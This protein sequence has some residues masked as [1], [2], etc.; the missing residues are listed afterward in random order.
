MDYLDKYAVI[1]QEI[2]S[3][4]EQPGKKII[5]KLF[6]LIERSGVTL[7]LNYSIHYF[8]PYS[9]KLDD[10][11]HV[12]ESNDIININTSGVTQVIH[13]AKNNP[14]KILSSQEKNKVDFILSKFSN[15]SDRELEAITTL[16]Y[17][18][19]SLVKKDFDSDRV[20]IELVKEIKGAKFN[21]ESLKQNIEL[22]K[23]CKLR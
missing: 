17:V 22:L 14:D 4:V 23:N 5:Q 2:C 13:M 11:I 18:A 15:K 6:Y 9:S 12:L 16:D 1:T 10:L 19:T 3:K 20:I 7:N 21:D 8:G